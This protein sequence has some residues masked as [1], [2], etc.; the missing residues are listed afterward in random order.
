MPAWVGWLWAIVTALGII[1]LIYKL[2]V[3]PYL[4]EHERRTRAFDAAEHLA[5]EREAQWADAGEA[6][7]ILH[8][9]WDDVTKRGP[10]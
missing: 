5:R 10:R 9:H 2:I 3:V 4:D 1:A 8:S 7:K 6:A